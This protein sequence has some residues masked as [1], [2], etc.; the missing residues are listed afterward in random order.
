MQIKGALWDPDQ[1]VPLKRLST[2]SYRENQLIVPPLAT[3]LDVTGVTEARR[4]L[5]I[6]YAGVG[7]AGPGTGSI[8]ESRA[9]E[10]CW[11]LAH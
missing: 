2:F 4:S 3:G 11:S 1:T 7:G 8:R 6:D 5:P 9:T 10:S